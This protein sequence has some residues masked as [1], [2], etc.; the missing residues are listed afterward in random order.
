MLSSAREF[1]RGPVWLAVGALG[2]VVTVIAILSDDF[3]MWLSIALSLMVAASFVR[4]HQN[5]LET[6]AAERSLPR[7]IDELHREGITLLEEL[8]QPVEP[9]VSDDGT[10]SISLGAPAERWD[11][12][13]AFDERIRELFIEAYPALLSDYTQRFN[14]YR[15]ERR[16]AEDARAPDP[17][18]DRRPNDVKLKEFTDYMHRKPARL[19]EASLEGLAAARHRVGN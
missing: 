7:R 6:E 16:A 10:V 1:V 9:E 15:R 3:W 12:A 18:T 13:E 14:E 5:R 4:F 17:E 11:K 8:D 19:L 2:V